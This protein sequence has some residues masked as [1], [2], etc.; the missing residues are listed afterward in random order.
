[1]K[2]FTEEWNGTDDID[3][4][5]EVKLMPGH[6][7]KY[8]NLQSTKDMYEKM[9][10]PGFG[11]ESKRKQT[12]RLRKPNREYTREHREE[13]RRHYLAIKAERAALKANLA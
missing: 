1:M 8:P 2:K 13:A 6:I 3:L 12:R 11:E 10:E 9:I 7:Y 5:V 4:F